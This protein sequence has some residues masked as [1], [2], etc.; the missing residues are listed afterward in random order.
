MNIFES[1]E[2]LNVSEECFDEIMGIVERWIDNHTVGEVRKIAKNA[3]DTRNSKYQES[4][5]KNGKSSPETQRL[6]KKKKY[7]ENIT[8]CTSSFNNSELNNRL[9]NIKNKLNKDKYPDNMRV[10]DAIV[11]ARRASNNSLHDNALASLGKAN[12]PKNAIELD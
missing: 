6:F 12:K 9:S 10:V 7:A 8:G 4:L 3:L 5:L 11:K 2:N 1:L